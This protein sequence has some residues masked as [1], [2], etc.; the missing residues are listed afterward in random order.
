[1]ATS[2]RERDIQPEMELHRAEAETEV[3]VSSDRSRRDWLIIQIRSYLRF[4]F[5][6]SSAIKKKREKSAREEAAGEGGGGG[7]NA[8]NAGESHRDLGKFYIAA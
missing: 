7:M 5:A 1:M 2:C 4:Q 8:T 3:A 6:L